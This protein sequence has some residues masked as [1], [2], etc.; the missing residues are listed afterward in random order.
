M[1]IFEE[2]ARVA[3]GFRKGITCRKRKAAVEFA[4]AAREVKCLHRYSAFSITRG[5]E[6]SLHDLWQTASASWRQVSKERRHIRRLLLCAESLRPH[7]HIDRDQAVMMMARNKRTSKSICTYPQWRQKWA[8]D[9][10]L[11]FLSEWN[12]AMKAGA[13]SV[14]G[15][16]HTAV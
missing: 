16:L 10:A 2:V 7:L 1:S 4:Q 15:W 6:E 5:H 8:C 9:V 13:T 12:A 3:R 11:S 14:V